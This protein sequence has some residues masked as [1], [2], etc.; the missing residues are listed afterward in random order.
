[1]NASILAWLRG[2]KPW[3]MLIGYALALGA[4]YASVELLKLPRFSELPGPTR[5]LKEWTSPDPSFGLS[6]H[7]PVYY[8]HILTSVRRVAVAFAL[9]TALGVPVGLLLGASPRF[10]DYVFPLL[11][12]L[13]PIPILAWV[14]LAIIMFE[15]SESPVVFLT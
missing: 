6:L 5:V 13:R 12:V 3:L 10:R 4:W 8:Q 9:A 1:M 15:G 11:E 7:T 14:P 2:P